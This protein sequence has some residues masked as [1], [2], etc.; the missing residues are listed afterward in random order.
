LPDLVP[1]YTIPT[2]SLRL[3]SQKC[4]VYLVP[5]NS[6]CAGKMNSAVLEK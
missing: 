6:K 4:S 3:T 5:M 1:Y 2:G